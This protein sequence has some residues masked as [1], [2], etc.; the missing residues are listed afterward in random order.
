[1]T[2]NNLRYMA[3]VERTGSITRA[4]AALGI[5]QPNLSKAI[6]DVEKE[7]GVPIFKRSA[8]GVV[9]TERGREFLQYARAILVQL[10]R[11]ETLSRREENETLRFSLL[12][13]RASYVTYA[14][15]RFLK[16]AGRDALDI[17]FRETNSISAINAVA[18]FEYDMGIVR[19]PAMYESYFMT[20][21]RE[22]ELAV[23][24]TWSFDYVLLTSRRGWLAQGPVD[25]EILNSCIEIRHGDE[26]IPNISE[27]YQQTDDDLPGRRHIY[28]YERGSQFDILA[29]CE[30]SF[31]WVSPMPQE[32][33]DRYGLVQREAPGMRSPMKDALIYPISFRLTGDHLEFIEELERVREEILPK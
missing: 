5:G 26:L 25:Q 29:S 33:L 2:I 10:D 12:L 17:R 21:I 3:E 19:F 14:F 20:L 8:K 32:I 16:K 22:K 23:H 4:A 27:L 11:I 7:V 15:T 9:P 1:M 31:M 6:R 24:S 28:V 13:P 18:E 30:D